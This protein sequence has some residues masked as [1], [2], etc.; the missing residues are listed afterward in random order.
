MFWKNGVHDKNVEIRRVIRNNQI[1]SFWKTLLTNWVY[2]Y[3]TQDSHSKTPN[4][5]DRKTPS[6]PRNFLKGNKNEWVEKQQGNHKN[7]PDIEFVAQTKNANHD[8]HTFKNT[9]FVLAT[10]EK[11]EIVCTRII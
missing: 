2:S 9:G 4:H 3:Q 6:S 5:I 1:R 11:I 10:V 8:F 7:Q